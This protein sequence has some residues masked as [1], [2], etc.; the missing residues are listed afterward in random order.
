MRITLKNSLIA[1][2]S[3]LT[4]LLIGLGWTSI[5]KLAEIEHN[6]ENAATVL[7]PS[8]SA[9]NKINGMTS[10]LRLKQMARLLSSE[11]EYV[12][13]IDAGIDK[14]TKDVAD[15][16]AKY[17][18]MITSEEEQQAYDKFAEQYAQY[19]KLFLE[20]DRLIDAGYREQATT[21]FR[22]E[23]L[24][25]F[26]SFSADLDRAVALNEA[27]ANSDYE[28]S[29]VGYNSARLTLFTVIGVGLLVS[30]G[31][32]AFVILG[33][34]RP[35]ERI[36]HVM[37]E[38]SEGRLETEIPYADKRNEI[39]EMSK[40]LSVFRDGLAETERLRQDQVEQAARAEEDKRR[41][42]HALADDFDA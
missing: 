10:E 11:A 12:R 23:M 5:D 22:G 2:L 41:A 36:T 1:V 17:E 31:A 40:A 16:R 3:L 42:M 39:G 4:L 7:V 13:T 35:I 27:E 28:A 14:A 38:L 8:I 25:L 26:D 24:T 32:I 34:A 18:P 30:L 19:Q 6:V 33:I 37:R 15:L 20:V 9:V 21:L 29:I